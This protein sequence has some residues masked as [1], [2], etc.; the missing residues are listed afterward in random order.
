MG[1]SDL[2]KT[3]LNIIFVGMLFVFISSYFVGWLI[4]ILYNRMDIVSIKNDNIYK[5]YIILSEFISSIIIFVLIIMKYRDNNTMKMAL[6]DKYNMISSI[7]I[8]MNPII[9]LAAVNIYDI[10]ASWFLISYHGAYFI[11]R[12]N[13]FISII[14]RYNRREYSIYSKIACFVIIVQSFFYTM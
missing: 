2:R 12:V 3:V 7:I 1:N 5:I 9:V 13:F 4:D 10:S 14:I 11:S 8:S 6:L